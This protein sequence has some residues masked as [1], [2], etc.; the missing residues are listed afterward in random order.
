MIAKYTV[1]DL[2]GDWRQF[3]NGISFKYP[4][5]VYA[6]SHQNCIWFLKNSSIVTPWDY[7]PVADVPKRH[8]AAILVLT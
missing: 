4:P 3:D 6:Y 7:I 2:E 5:G 1:F 8:R